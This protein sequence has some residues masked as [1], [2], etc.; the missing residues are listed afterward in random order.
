MRTIQAGEVSCACVAAKANSAGHSPG[1]FIKQCLFTKVVCFE[2]KVDFLIAF[3][4][5][6]QDPG[7]AILDDVKS[8][9]FVPL[10]SPSAALA[11]NLLFPVHGLLK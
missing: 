2:E 7:A 8:V 10:R 6:L 5:G 11:N 9:S 3:T 4:D 1:H